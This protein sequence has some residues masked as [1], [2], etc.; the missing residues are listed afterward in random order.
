MSA[1]KYPSIFSR[2]MEAIVYLLSLLNITL[3]VS[4]YLRGNPTY[5]CN[6][7]L[8]G[9]MTESI[10]AQETSLFYIFNHVFVCS[11]LNPATIDVIP[12]KLFYKQTFVKLGVINFHDTNIKKNAITNCGHHACLLVSRLLK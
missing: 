9:L 5:Q 7:T 2:Q 8:F 12:L 3:I 4:Q 1:D 11:F 10:Y 6:E